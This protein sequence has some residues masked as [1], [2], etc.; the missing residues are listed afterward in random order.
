MESLGGP[1]P[2]RTQ[3]PNDSMIGV[4]FEGEGAKAIRPRSR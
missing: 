1:L 2:K 3:P 4:A